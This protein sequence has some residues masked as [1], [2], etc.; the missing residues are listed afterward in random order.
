VKLSKLIL[1][2]SGCLLCAMPLGGCAVEA[3]ISTPAPPPDRS[4]SITVQW[5][6]ASTAAPAQC[7]YYR[8]D[9][10]ELVI[11]DEAGAKVITTDA[12]CEAFAVQVDLPPGVYHADATLVDVNKAPR[13]LTLPLNDLDVTTGTDLAVDTDFPARSFL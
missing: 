1:G 10:L 2:F 5:T 3:G 8:A 9:S 7:A 11:Y 12:P 13:S 4:G 6:I